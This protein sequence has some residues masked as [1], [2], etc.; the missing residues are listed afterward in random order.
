[1][2]HTCVY[3]EFFLFELDSS[4]VTKMQ[5]WILNLV[6]NL[7]QNRKVQNEKAKKYPRVA[8]K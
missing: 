3:M 8:I 7:I 5:E 2:L 1:M 6:L 4:Q